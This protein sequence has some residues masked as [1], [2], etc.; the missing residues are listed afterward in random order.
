MKVTVNGQT[1]A[2]V[3]ACRTKKAAKNRAVLHC[4]LSLKVLTDQQVKDYNMESG[5]A[6]GVSPKPA[7]VNTDSSSSGSNSISESSVSNVKKVFESFQDEYVRNYR[8]RLKEQES[9]GSGVVNSGAE[10]PASMWGR[11]AQHSASLSHDSS[12]ASPGFNRNNTKSALQY[13]D[14]AF[15]PP[16]INNLVPQPP[17]S[18]PPPGVDSLNPPESFPP[19]GVQNM[20]QEM[21][22]EEQVRRMMEFRTVMGFSSQN[23]SEST[24]ADLACEDVISQYIRS[25]RPTAAPLIQP[26]EE[27]PPPGASPG[28]PDPPAYPPPPPPEDNDAPPE[29]KRRVLDRLG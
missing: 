21:T 12:S 18:F 29:K 8:T 2:G 17:K 15:P 5:G 24:P 20:A 1:Y 23:R 16:G 4:L 22:P 11:Y 14:Q 9:S 10:D 6:F 25:L 3:E 7:A 26:P 13:D 28:P 19:P 27:A